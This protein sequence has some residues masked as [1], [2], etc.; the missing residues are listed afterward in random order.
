MP[1]PR[2]V[3]RTSEGCSVE[4][5]SRTDVKATRRAEKCLKRLMVE[6]AGLREEG[7]YAA[8]IIVEDHDRAVETETPRGQEPV[9]IV[10]ERE[11]TDNE[12]GW[13]GSGRGSAQGTRDHA[14]DAVGATIAHNANS[15]RITS[16]ECVRVAN[17]HAVADHEC[18]A[19][20]KRRGNVSQG[21][22]LKGVRL[23]SRCLLDRTAR[24]S[25]DAD[26]TI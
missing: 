5:R 18:R 15:S 4:T 19:V 11:I 12:D 1:Q 23:R 3:A 22:P 8:T 25:I 13:S 6:L 24:R 21:A 10:V 14:V 26:P 20:G 9:E 7:K 17:R 16:H 2:S